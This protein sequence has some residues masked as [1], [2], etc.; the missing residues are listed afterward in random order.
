MAKMSVTVCDVCREVIEEPQA[1]AIHAPLGSY[2]VDL[3]EDHGEALHQ[4]IQKV[5]PDHEAVPRSQRARRGF[6]NRIM[7]ME[8]IAALRKEA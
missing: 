7:T 8:Q 1:W 6:E 2:L 3:C 5:L 4:S